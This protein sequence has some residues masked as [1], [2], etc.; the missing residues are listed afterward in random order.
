MTIAA[1][2]GVR[3]ST[4]RIACIS[5]MLIGKLK[6]IALTLNF[7]LITTVMSV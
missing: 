5:R 3:G 4:P 7:K 1:K 2:S 6:K